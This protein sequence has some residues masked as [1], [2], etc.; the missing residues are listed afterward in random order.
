MQYSCWVKGGSSTSQSA[1][2]SFKIH[3]NEQLQVTI[4]NAV[5]RCEW[6]S[7]LVQPIRKMIYF[8]PWYKIIRNTYDK[9]PKKFCS[10]ESC[11]IFHI[12]YLWEWSA[13]SIYR[14]KIKKEVPHI[15]SKCFLYW[16]LFGWSCML[17]KQSNYLKNF[18]QLFSNTPYHISICLHF[19]TA[20][21]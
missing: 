3:Q 6:G 12:L 21:I 10:T 15:F 14:F 8:S 1:K 18:D 4:R 16:I 19:S 17:V 2:C 5:I 9:L 13:T 7:G 11:F 20:S